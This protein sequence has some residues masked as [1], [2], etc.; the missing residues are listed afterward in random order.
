M[1]KILRSSPAR[2]A[3]GPQAWWAVASVAAEHQRLDR[4]KERLNAKDH[5][6]DECDRVDDMKE[7]PLPGAEIRVSEAV[8]IA[9]VGVCDAVAARRYPVESAREKRLQKDRDRSRLRRL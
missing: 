1:K 8:V 2:C 7:H 4:Q 6:V 5:G 9:R 3:W